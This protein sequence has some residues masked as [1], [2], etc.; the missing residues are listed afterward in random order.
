MT[1]TISPVEAFIKS[2]EQRLQAHPDHD[3]AVNILY[4]LISM[5]SLTN[6]R[7][8]EV[9]KD[10]KK[11]ID[12]YVEAIKEGAYGYDLLNRDKIDI[13]LA[14]LNYLEQKELMQYALSVTSRELPEHDRN[15]FVD[16]KHYAEKRHIF[17]N[18]L[19]TM[20]PKAFLLHCNQ[21]MISIGI[22]LILYYFAV[23]ILLL[24]A[25]Y[26]SMGIFEI[27]YEYYS[28]HFLLNHAMNVL[29]RFALIESNF[30]IKP[31]NWWALLVMIVGKLTFIGFIVHF[32]YKKLSDKI[33]VK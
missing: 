14:K 2:E 3:T 29:S 5:K 11:F 25:P 21:S 30:K 23:V 15:W 16:K 22:V 24:P 28:K 17:E 7:K 4:N 33:A 19:V 32:I 8:D 1:A 18:R 6:N 26:E 9:Y 13:V 12:H 31:T 10:A 27:K 20:Y